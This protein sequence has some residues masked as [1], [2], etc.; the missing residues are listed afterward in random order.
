MSIH[1]LDK[2][3]ER[4]RTHD[5]AA[6]ARPTSRPTSSRSR[7]TRRESRSW[8]SRSWVRLPARSPWWLWCSLLVLGLLIA[9][10]VEGARRQQPFPPAGTVHWL[11]G[12]TT[13]PTAALTLEA[14]YSGAANFAIRLDHWET[15][16]A[17]AL[18]PIRA[19]ST[20]SLQMPLGRYRMTIVKGLMWQGPGKLF[21]ITTDAREVVEPLEFT[22][23]GN[24]FSGHTIQLETLGGN[25]ETRRA[26]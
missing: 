11:D 18:V 10:M 8:V 15:R 6:S 17:V 7:H 2:Y 22:R 1:D 19:G 26:R 4:T 23:V 21:H 5:R 12:P 9:F 25:M 16:K 20:T 14:P 3:R 13:G 24:N